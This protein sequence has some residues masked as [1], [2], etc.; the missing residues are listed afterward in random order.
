[1]ELRIN[2]C[3][4]ELEA[5]R[6][7]ALVT[8]LS[9]D[10]SSPRGAGAK[11]LVTA[12]GIAA[13]IGGGALEAK[14]IEWARECICDRRSRL[15]DVDLTGKEENS[16]D[17]ACGGRVKLLITYVDASCE[18]TLRVFRFLGECQ[19][20]SRP[21][22][23]LTAFEDEGEVV[24][25]WQAAQT[26]KR[27][28]KELYES[29]AA[30]AEEGELTG[31]LPD[32]AM[33]LPEE[34]TLSDYRLYEKGE[35]LGLLSEQV[36][37]LAHLYL[38]GGGHVALK[39]AQLGHFLGMDVTVFEDRPEFLAEDR[40]PD[41]ERVLTPDYK[42]IFGGLS[43]GGRDCI[44]I[45]TR[46]HRY[47]TEVLLQ[48]VQ[49]KVGYIGMI[50]SRRKVAMAMETLRSHGVPEEVIQSVHSP[51]G[52]SIGAETPAEIAVSIL[53]EIIQVLKKA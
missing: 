50:G 28:E 30:Q 53:A 6:D 31:T 51:I 9:R 13:T 1:M 10:G 29:Q 19:E 42:G 26:G 22:R 43:V 33:P 37:A 21:C 24:H 27:N 18:E 7:F 39:T 16:V 44:V 2:L 8:L 4:Q 52:L 45:L 11:M 35:G 36:G 15:L 25:V 48:A 46:G 49:T 40:F 47:D 14:V 32:W 34:E 3:R 5:G 38:C 23:W 12:S 41:A 17:M 20:Q